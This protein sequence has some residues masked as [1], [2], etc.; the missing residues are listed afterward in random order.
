MVTCLEA[1]VLLGKNK[2]GSFGR[3]HRLSREEYI[4][5][6][7]CDVTHRGSRD[8]SKRKLS[9]C[10]RNQMGNE[11]IL[12]LPE[13]AD[14]FVVYYDVRSNDLEACLEKGRRGIYK[15]DMRVTLTTSEWSLQHTF[16]LEGYEQGKDDGWML[17]VIGFPRPMYHLGKANV[18]LN[19]RKKD[20]S[21]RK[22]EID[23]TRS[24]LVMVVE[25]L[26]WKVYTFGNE[27]TISTGL[28]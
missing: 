10:G 16:N 1:S 20:E 12:A 17:L 26:T 19:V 2:G 4:E 11:P 8:Q 9:E 22:F 5:N 18:D 7:V 25:G 28:L 3:V 15:R 13:G 21:Q 27:R 14:D 6:F 24:D 23:G